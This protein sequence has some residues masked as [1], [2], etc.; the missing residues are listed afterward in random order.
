ML[1]NL[2]FFLLTGCTLSLIIWTGF[3]LFRNQEDPLAER[4]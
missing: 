2:F 4:L 1:T 3:E